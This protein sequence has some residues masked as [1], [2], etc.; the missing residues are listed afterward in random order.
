[1]PDLPFSVT[2]SVTFINGSDVEL[3]FDTGLGGPFLS[4]DANFVVTDN[5][6]VSI[7]WALY[8]TLGGNNTQ[9]QRCVVVEP[10]GTNISYHCD[11]T[12]DQPTNVHLWFYPRGQGSFPRTL[13]INGSGTFHVQP[14]GNCQFGTRV[15]IGAVLSQALTT[16]SVA[17]LLANVAAGGLLA[18]FADTVGAIVNWDGICGQGPGPLPSLPPDPTQWSASQKLAFLKAVAWFSYCECVPGIPAPTPFPL[19]VIPPTSISIQPP[20]FPCSD[21]DPCGALQQILSIV[22]S[23]QGSLL[24]TRSQVDLLQRYKLPFAYI[25]GATHPTISGTVTLSIPSG[26][27]GLLVTVRVQP[28]SVISAP[29][30]PVYE[31]DLGWISVLD[32]NGFIDEKRLTRTT[33]LWFP[34]IMSDATRVGLSLNTGVTIDVTELQAEP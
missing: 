30:V 14:T 15:K 3:V 13:Q 26:L 22:S 31:R 9:N 33:Q 1:M 29:G 11:Y 21:V 34:P 24:T 17:T 12:A 27:I 20:V 19:P 2:N 4:V 23:M 8:G 10:F 6:G 28:T 32:S 7:N 5:S 16:S 25:V 18:V